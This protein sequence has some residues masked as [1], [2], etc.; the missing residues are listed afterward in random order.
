MEQAG[1][2]LNLSA[3]TFLRSSSFSQAFVLDIACIASV[4]IELHSPFCHPVTQHCRKTENIF[5]LYQKINV[6]YI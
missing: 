3:E 5:H 2:F 1:V 4:S 6:L